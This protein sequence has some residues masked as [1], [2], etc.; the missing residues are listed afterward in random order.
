MSS[1]Q[2]GTVNAAE[3]SSQSAEQLRQT[4][5]EDLGRALFFDVNLSLY[6]T[7]SCATCHDPARAFTDWRDSGVAAAASQGA[8]M[9]SLGDRNAPTASYAAHVPPFGLNAA[10]DYA[11]GL[12]W[13]GRV[14]SLEE[15]ASAPPQNPIE[16]AMPD[17]ATVVQ[18]LQENPNYLYAFK[19]LFGDD[20]FADA[21]RAYQAMAEAIAALERTEFFSPFDSKYDRYLRD[22]YQPT[23]QEELGM[24]LF[25]SN[26]FTNC[27]KCHQLQQ[28]PEAQQE[29]FSNFTYQNIGVPKNVA[30]RAVNGKGEDF[31]DHG[32]LEHPEVDDVAQDGKFR[33]PTLRNVAI[34]APYMHN[35]LFRE[36]RTVVQFY[37]KYLTRSSK[38][39]INPETGA[40]WGEPEVPRNLALDKLQQ[41][42]ALDTR[43]V[44]AL[45]A[46]M[47]MLT[48]QR[49]E[50]LLP[51]DTPA[52]PVE[53]AAK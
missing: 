45:V 16:M 49:Y 51:A 22:E 43:S 24:T 41:G 1:A 12:F 6:R 28:L 21:D 29:I 44:D 50:A 11:G 31:V 10:G 40:P 27:N 25:F 17:N 13:D 37:N 18:R 4:K 39:Q 14:A 42:R 30:L 5:L 46:F 3:S 33:V 7:Q 34:T 8:D 2:N 35:G 53:S 32:L 20:I 23:E 38:A 52:S 48:D 9:K 15:Q 47:R 36:L 19:G 26:Q